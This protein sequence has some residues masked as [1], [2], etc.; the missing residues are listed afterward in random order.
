VAYGT[1]T[2]TSATPHAALSTAIQ[3]LFN[4]DATGGRMPTRNWSFVENVPAGVGA[5]QSG[6]AA[7]SVDVYKCAGS[8]TDANKDATDYFVGFR[9]PVT[10]GAVGSN[11]QVFQAYDGSAG[12]KKCKRMCLS[13][14][15]TGAP[16]GAGFWNTDTYTTFNAAA[17][18]TAFITPTL[19]TT[20][21]TYYIK[22]TKD[23]LVV[24]CHVGSTD[25]AWGMFLMDSIISVSDPTT[26]I[27]GSLS[28]AGYSS[29]PSV[30]DATVASK[31]KCE[32]VPWN[33]LS[34]YTNLANVN[35]FWLS[36]KTPVSRVLVRSTIAVANMYLAGGERGLL[37]ADYM[38]VGNSTAL[39]GDTLTIDGNTWVMIGGT[40]TGPLPVGAG[41]LSLITRNG[42]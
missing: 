37:P 22:I 16:V 4:L 6:S 7:Y 30:V 23:S 2:I 32:I 29:L 28:V 20:G 21:F 38:F 13:S 24:A 11:V 9:I 14:T 19:N 33:T 42:I 25:G 12:Q 15:G 18:V 26:L 3:A 17:S 41:T 40:A 10:D 31:F 34:A 5:G 36:N 1:G 35:N 27:G 8:G 39:L